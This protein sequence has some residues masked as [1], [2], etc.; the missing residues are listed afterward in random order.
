MTPNDDDLSENP[1]P[2]GRR[3]ICGNLLMSMPPDQARAVLGR[4]AE[5][6]PDDAPSMPLAQKDQPAA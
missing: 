6:E 2:E 4:L 5:Q 3:G 1:Q